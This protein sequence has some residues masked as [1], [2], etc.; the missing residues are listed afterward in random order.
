MPKANSSLPERVTQDGRIAE[1]TTARKAHTAD[2]CS[3]PIEPNALYYSVTL[4]SAGVS[5]LW[6]TR[7]A[8]T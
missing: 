3:Y 6:H 4:A 7:T 1:L 2:C 8:F 5:S